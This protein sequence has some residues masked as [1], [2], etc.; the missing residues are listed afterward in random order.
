MVWH[1]SY[2]HGYVRRRFDF[3]SRFDRE[4]K[5]NMALDR[6]YYPGIRRDDRRDCGYSYRQKRRDRLTRRKK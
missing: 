1:Y 5:K 4:S 6:C 2:F 3:S